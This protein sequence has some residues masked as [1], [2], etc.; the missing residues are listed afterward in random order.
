MFD[1]LKPQTPQTL[2]ENIKDLIDFNQ[3]LSKFNQLL[4]NVNPSLFNFECPVVLTG[5]TV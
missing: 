5:G 1:H 3:V 2:S 4:P